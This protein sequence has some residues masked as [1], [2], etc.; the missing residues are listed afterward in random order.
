DGHHLDPWLAAV[1]GDAQ[2]HRPLAGVLVQV[3]GRFGDREGQLVGTRRGEPQPAR[4]GLGGATAGGGR[5]GVLDPQ[6][7]HVA[8][9]LGDQRRAQRDHLTTMTV[10]PV[11]GLESS[12][13]SSTSRRA[14]DSPRPRPFPDVQPSVSARPM[15]A[16]PGP[17]SAKCSLTPARPL[18]DLTTSIRARPPP[19]CTSVFRA[20]SLAAVTS[21]VWS[22]SDSPFSAAAVR[23]CWRTRTTSSPDWIGSSSIRT[24]RS[25][26]P[27]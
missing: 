21:L 24:S 25:G 2:Q 27:A 11:P 7:A 5:A 12:S 1:P 14:P 10:V 15:S 8:R 26:S 13:N 4:Q 3:G 23:T 16:M 20:S 19:P 22:T 17:S 9:H 18:A 6:P